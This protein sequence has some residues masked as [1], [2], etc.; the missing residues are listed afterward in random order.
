V[1][2]AVDVLTPAGVL[3]SN[4]LD[5]TLHDPVTLQDVTIP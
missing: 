1:P 4:E 5:Y 2:K 3:Q